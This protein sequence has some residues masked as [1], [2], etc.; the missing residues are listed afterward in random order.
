MEN[1]ED[2]E[3]WLSIKGACTCSSKK[4]D[5]EKCYECFK[6]MFDSEY[7]KKQK[8]EAEGEQ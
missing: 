1:K 2:F 6:R 3:K 8:K 5:R 7:F 4:T